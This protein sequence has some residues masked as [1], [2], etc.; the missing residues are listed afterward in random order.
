MNILFHFCDHIPKWF[1]KLFHNASNVSFSIQHYT[2]WTCTGYSSR[3]TLTVHLA[4]SGL[5]LIIC[6]VQ[7]PEFEGYPIHHHAYPLTLL[8]LLLDLAEEG[9][10]K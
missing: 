10:L 3:E 6:L 1:L 9:D 7:L 4:Q 5:K 2:L 8:S